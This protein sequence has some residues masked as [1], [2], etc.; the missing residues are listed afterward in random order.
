M[1]KQDSHGTRG[2][3]AALFVWSVAL[4]LGLL[5]GW[6]IWP[7]EYYD[8]DPADLRWED[9]ETYILLVS[10]SYALHGD[11][12]QARSRLAALGEEDIG[13]VVGEL[14]REYMISGEEPEV[15][16]N[17]VEL[18]E[19]LG[20][21]VSPQVIA[22]V[23]TATPT[24]T[25]TATPT[26]TET[27][28]PTPS[29]TLETAITPTPYFLPT[30]TATS[31]AVPT[32]IGEFISTDV[33]RIDKLHDGRTRFVVFLSL[34]DVGLANLEIYLHPD[35]FV[36][37][38][39]QVRLTVMW[40]EELAALE[41]RLVPDPPYGFP[42][43]AVTITDVV[44]AYPAMSADLT[45]EGLEI[46][47]LQTPMQA[48]LMNGTTEWLWNVKPLK[49]GSLEI[50]LIVGIP[51]RMG[52]DDHLLRRP[53]P[54]VPLQ[55]S[56]LDALPTP[57][58]QPAVEFGAIGTATAAP[59]ATATSSPSPFASPPPIAA[60]APA[61]AP[62]AIATRPARPGL[63]LALFQ[64]LAEL[65]GRLGQGALACLGT[66]ALALVS[67]IGILRTS[68]AGRSSDSTEEHH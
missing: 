26:P 9:K 40:P 38:S 51:V 64:I 52:A 16:R 30:P 4:G 28:A 25:E 14:A 62:T 39:Y 61:P 22:Y 15:T 5:F 66:V 12:A 35:M 1:W 50:T 56:V 44:A 6:V 58:A 34:L 67:L 11:L 47:A 45:G 2:F 23:A 13:S 19:D 32:L 24:P 49:A 68:R 60:S 55:I 10:N 29:P 42:S 37:S 36:G 53:C 31:T 7:V 54:D 3:W 27:P 65:V 59:T 57:T 18:A 17:L 20:A 46:R 48:R 63:P 33:S 8:T 43:R 41:T 21:A